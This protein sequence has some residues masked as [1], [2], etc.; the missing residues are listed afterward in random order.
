M[1]RA[2]KAMIV[3]DYIKLF[4]QGMKDRKSDW[5]SLVSTCLHS[6]CTHLVNMHELW[7]YV[8]KHKHHF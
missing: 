7:N 2:T 1:L 3:L 8:L 5:L 4:R 6:H